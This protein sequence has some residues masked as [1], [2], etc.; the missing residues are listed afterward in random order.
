MIETNN[1]SQIASHLVISLFIFLF[2][3]ICLTSFN[4]SLILLGLLTVN[5]LISVFGVVFLNKFY[6]NSVGV[7]LSVKAV[8]D[9][10]ILTVIGLLVYFQVLSETVLF[11]VFFMMGFIALMVLEIKN[12]LGKV[13]ENV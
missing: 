9:I 1:R 10:L 6:S 7:T 5:S 2:S 11:T 4:D 12:V 8:K 13:T 3:M